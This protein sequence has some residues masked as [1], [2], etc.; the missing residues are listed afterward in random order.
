IFANLRNVLGN[1]GQLLVMLDSCHCGSA[2][3][4]GKTRGGEGVLVP[5]DWKKPNQSEANKGSELL[6]RTQL[7]NDA[8]PFVI[9]S[10]A[11]ADELNYEHDGAGSFSYA[12][13]K[14]LYELGCDFTYRRL[15]SSIAVYMNSIAP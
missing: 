13:S 15:F 4:G 7:K 1:E 11:S 14:S 6:E 3:R 8:A 12:F 10:G 9:I 2:T 5:S